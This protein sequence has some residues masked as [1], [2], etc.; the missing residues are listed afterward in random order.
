MKAFMDEHFLLKNETAKR[1][2]RNCIMNMRQKC[3][4][5]IIIVT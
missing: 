3:R 1:L 4:L 2:Y 5:S